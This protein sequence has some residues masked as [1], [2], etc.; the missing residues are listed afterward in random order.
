[1]TNVDFKKYFAIFGGGGIRGISYCGAYRA[2]LENNIQLTGCAGS[3]IGAVFASLL[4][5]GYNTDEIYEILSNTGFEMFIDLNIDIKKEIAFSKGKIFYEWIKEKIEKKYYGETY[6]KNEVPP[7]TFKMLDYNLIIYST[8]LTNLSFKEFS[9]CITPDFEIAK[10]VRASVSMPGLFTPLEI[11][12]N[13]VVDGDLMKSS[14]L[15]RLSDKIK[16]L[17]ERIVEF[18]LEDNQT[19]KNPA[20]SIEYLNRVYNAISGFATDYIINMY[21]FKDKFDYIKINTDN[22]SVIDFLIS[23]DKKRDLSEIGYK[24]TS[25]YF[26]NRFPKKQKML[27]EKY[28]SLISKIIKFKDEFNKANIIKSYLR[29]CELFVFLC[30]E[31]LYLDT[32]IFEKIVNFKKDYCEN[33]KIKNFLGI[34]SAFLLNNKKNDMKNIL[35]E[36]IEDVEFKIDELKN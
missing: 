15:W 25:Y 23:K 34:K 29:L 28:T 27:F 14:P 17:K 19:R 26:K 30:E 3:S 9:S 21:E 24:T 8:D 4:A 1:M 33:F 7:V 16:N 18:R 6:K 20:N 2:L 5:I 13:L 11:D 22:V 12:G 35:D 32:Y 31:K 10:A 36:I